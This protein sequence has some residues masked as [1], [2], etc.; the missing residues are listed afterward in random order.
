M[1]IPMTVEGAEKLR[2]ELLRL[3]NVERPRIRRVCP[4]FTPQGLY[5]EV[6]YLGGLQRRGA[7]PFR[8]IRE[9]LSGHRLRLGVVEVLEQIS[10]FT[11]CVGGPSLPRLG[12]TLFL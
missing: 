5:D 12:L 1:S 10:N 7:V 8:D 3:K 9:Q 2:E 11:K 6:Q 4:P